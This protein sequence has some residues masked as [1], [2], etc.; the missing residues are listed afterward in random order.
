MC[1]SA[2]LLACTN[3]GNVLQLQGLLQA[4]FPPINDSPSALT[5]LLQTNDAPLEAEIQTAREV[6]ADETKRLQVLDENI[7]YM[8]S[9]LAALSQQ[10]VES[11]EKILR[12]KSI[13]SPLRCI[14]PE[15][16]GNFF[17]SPSLAFF[18]IG[19]HI[20]PWILTHVCSHWRNISLSLPSLW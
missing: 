18:E 1:A 17:C 16:L 15:I 8:Q 13:I 7:A 4:L 9:V 12:H 5:Y 3:C 11:K 2:P 19:I 20:S 14:P 6:I 10:R